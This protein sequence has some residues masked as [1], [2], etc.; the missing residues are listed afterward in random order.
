M[1]NNFTCNLLTGNLE[2]LSPVNFRLKS[3]LSELDIFKEISGTLKWNLC[4]I[5]TR[6]VNSYEIMKKKIGIL[7]G[8]WLASL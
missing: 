2:N 6:N 7:N 5:K 1:K 4:Y 8:E 3:I